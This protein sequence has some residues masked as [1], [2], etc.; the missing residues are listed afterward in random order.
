MTDTN[1]DSEDYAYADINGTLFNLPAGP[2]KGSLGVE[3]RFEKLSDN[4]DTLQQEGYAAGPTGPSGG[5]YNVSSAYAEFRVPLLTNLPFVQDLVFSPS[6]RFDHYSNFGDAT[7]YKLGGTWDIVPSFRI[8][9]SYS[10]GFRAPNLTELFGGNAVSYVSVAGDPCDSRAVGLNGNSNAGTGSLAPGSTCATA[11][12]ATGLNAAQIANYHSSE[13]DLVTDQRGLILGGNAN[14]KPEKSVQYN[15]G[16]VFTPTFLKGFSANADYYSVRVSNSIITGGIPN[17]FGPD[18]VVNGCYGPAQNKAYCALITRNSNGIF[19]ISSQNTNFGKTQVKGLDMEAAYDTGRAGL[20][21]PFPGA[22]KVDFQVERQF[23]NN[24]QQPDG[25]VADYNGHFLYSNEAVEPRWKG[26]ANFDYQFGKVD[27]HYDAQW[28]GHAYDL[29]SN[30]RVLGDYLP[31]YF[32]HNISATIQL[33]AYS[34]MKEP[35]LTVGINNLL[36]KDPPFLP[37]DSICKCNSFAGPY[38]FDGRAF[39][40]R[41]SSKF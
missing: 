1:Y 25:T 36:D 11:L 19:Q 28:I 27:F 26:R 8:R 13:N 7:T 37:G 20:T 38:D 29:G 33:P 40:A 21:L 23:Q 34:L 6:A 22:V 32:Y 39:F 14:L 16:V 18:I 35:S 15:I 3:R 24:A 41:L 10:T 12:A 17:N 9:A 5:S 31:D 30:T 4:P 2:L